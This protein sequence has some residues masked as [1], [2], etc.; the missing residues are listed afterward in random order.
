MGK[1]KP[2]DER[3]AE[4]ARIRAAQAASE[5]RRRVLVI[6]SVG[7]VVVALVAVAGGVILA[8]SRRQA[9]VQEAAASPIPGVEEEQDL[10]ANHVAALPEP[11]PSTPGGTL[12]PPMGGDHDPVVQNCGVYTEPVATANA[13]H[14]LEH[15]AVWITYRPGLD[16][17]QVETLTTLAGGYDFVLLSPFEDLKAPIVLTAWGVQLEVD[18]P[19]DPRVEEFLVKYVQ[20]P[21][22]PEPG[23]ACSGGVGTP[24]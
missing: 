14:S 4:L 18:D 19:A 22:T 23:A 21:Q 11:T 13:V 16:P 1:K 5:R 24:A 12:L 8:E 15:G 10:S 9:A 6:A 2:A 7:A 17:S 3:Q 20:G